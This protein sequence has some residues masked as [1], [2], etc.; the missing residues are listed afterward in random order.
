MNTT[1]TVSDA[2]AAVSSSRA[3]RR[4]TSLRL[5]GGMTALTLAACS[6]GDDVSGDPT[7]ATVESGSLRGV[8]SDN[9]LSFKGIPYAAAPVGDLRWRAPRPAASWSGLRDASAYG[10][11][12]MQLPFASDAAPIRT[13]PS[14]DCLVLNVWR[15]AENA[16]AGGARK[17]PVLVWIHGGGYT[18]GGSSPAVYDGT[19]FAKHGL[20]FVSLNYRLGRFGFFAHPALTSSQSNE[21][22]GN[23]GYMDQIAALQWVQR[24]IAAFGGDPNNVTIF[25]ES[26]GGESVHSLI[27]SPLAKGLFSK[28]IVESGS[29]RVNQTYG[30]YLTATGP[31]NV[32][33]GEQLGMA[34]AQSIGIAGNDVN[35]LTQLR[36]LTADQVVNGLNLG[37]VSSANATWSAGPMIDGK[38][39]IDEPGRLYA[40]GRYNAVSL[41]VGTNDADLAIPAPAKTK[42]DAYAIFGSQNLAAARSAFDPTGTASVRDVVSEIARVELMHEPARFVAR[43]VTAHGAASYVYRFSYVAQSLKGKVSGAVHA[44]EIPYVFDTL[45]AAYGS[46]V[47]DQDERVAQLANAY[48]AD[49]AKSGNPNASGRPV[50]QANDA[51]SNAVLEFTSAGTAVAD[52]PDPLKTQLDLVEPVNDAALGI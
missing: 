35:A 23:Y 46:Q 16:G 44:A 3:R 10:H 45:T 50:W 19:Q 52:L 22:L 6:G 4:R 12:C 49:F 47:T 20:V 32:A 30:R 8:A 7:V 37:T 15:P 14:E 5:I 48:W 36:A 39:V 9:V 34:F 11:D 25:G 40:S 18:N 33:S 41:L 17:W 21:P 31:G 1:K 2:G 26:A 27:R 29:G 38:L 24:N 51:S 43:T 13:A 28:A 42:D